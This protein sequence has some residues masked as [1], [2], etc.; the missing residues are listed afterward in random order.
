[1]IKDK[2]T[3]ST[4]F[5]HFDFGNTN[6]NSIDDN[7]NTTTQGTGFTLNPFFSCSC[8]RGYSLTSDPFNVWKLQEEVNHFSRG[9]LKRAY[10]L[11]G[12]F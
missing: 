11:G 5:T 4:L 10:R 1:M 2:L 8:R 9:D 7:L 12:G 3:Q 6:S